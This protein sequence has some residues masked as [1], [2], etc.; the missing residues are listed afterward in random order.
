MPISHSADP[1][2]SDD[3]LTTFLC[4]AVA[5]NRTEQ[6]TLTLVLP[7][8]VVLQPAFFCDLAGSWRDLRGKVSL[9]DNVVLR[10]DCCSDEA[11]TGM[12]RGFGQRFEQWRSQLAINR[13]QLRDVISLTRCLIVG[14]PA[15][16]PSAIVMGIAEPSV[17]LPE[18]AKPA[19][20]S[21]P[22]YVMNRV[23]AGSG[24]Y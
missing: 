14:R 2:P 18:W 22:S 6:K 21:M 12:L 20:I 10:V 8:S 16:D 7:E 11:Q 5:T 9:G 24:S 13:N 23:N 3:T 4:H 17:S 19:Q 1:I 15:R